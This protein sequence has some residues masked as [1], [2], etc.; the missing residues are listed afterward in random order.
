MKHECP[1]PQQMGSSP[2]GAGQHSV[3]TRWARVGL[4][5][6]WGAAQGAKRQGVMLVLSVSGKKGTERSQGS[7]PFKA[8]LTIS[9]DLQGRPRNKNNT[10]V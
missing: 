4:K 10:T 5:E 2:A 9:S 3:N 7:D 8:F 6:V 1:Q